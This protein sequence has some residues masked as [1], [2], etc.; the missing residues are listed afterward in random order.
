LARYDLSVAVIEKEP[1]AAFG[2][3][4]RNSGVLHSGINYAPGTLRAALSVRG[5]AMMDGIC[6]EL[7]VPIRRTGKLTIALDDRD[8]PG[9]Y[10]QYEQGRANGVPGMELMDNSAMRRIQPGIGGMLGLWTPSS[11]IISPYGLAMALAENAH[12]NGVEFCMSHKVESAA[13]SRDGIFEVAA[14]DAVGG[15]KKTFKAKTLVNSAGLYSDEVSR[16]LGVDDGTIYA[17]R[18]EYFVLDKRLEGAL[19]TLIYPVPGPNDPGLGIHLTPTVD[20]NILIGP[21]A[22]YVPGPDREDCSTTAPVME[23]LRRE[24]RRL[25]PSLGAGDYI[26]SFSGNR[27]KQTPPAVGGNADFTIEGARVPGFIRLQGIESPGLTSAPAIAEMVGDLIVRRAKPSLRK[28]FV[29]GR[30]GLAERFSLLP[31][32]TRI[33][34]AKSDPDYGEIV[35]RCEGVTKR[36][37]RDAIETPLTRPTLA[38]VKYRS[39]AMMGRCQGGF[40]LPRIMRMLREEY[41]FDGEGVPSATEL[42]RVESPWL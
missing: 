14:R 1:D 33:E 3:S 38:G 27:P 25:L 4:C 24:G 30:P 6:A 2:T 23:T 5:N 40:C 36:E 11:A 12:A 42:M 26:R 19:N 21:S 18:G 8:L 29:A 39:R 35:C 15:G 17:C 7:K 20:G 37:V 22:E 10:R 16:M 28:N 31:M 32:E 13:M 34:L 41:G 9:L